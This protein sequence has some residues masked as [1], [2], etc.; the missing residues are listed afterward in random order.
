M[1]AGCVIGLLIFS[2]VLSWLLIHVRSMTFAFLTGLMLGSVNKLWP[3]KQVDTDTMVNILPQTY[4]QL[5]GESAQLAIAI[6]MA[7]LAIYH[8]AGC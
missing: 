5:T 4:E 6:P 7:L 8:S 1:A 2:R 3:W